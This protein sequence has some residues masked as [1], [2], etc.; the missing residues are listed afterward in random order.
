M[1]NASHYLWS[2]F[3]F[4]S[5]RFIKLEDLF[6]L[7]PPPPT[8]WVWSL[9]RDSAK[10]QEMNWFKSEYCQ[11]NRLP[12]N[13]QPVTETCMLMS[14]L[15][16]CSVALRWHRAAVCA[17]A[18]PIV[19]AGSCFN[20][21]HSVRPMSDSFSGIAYSATFWDSINTFVCLLYFRL[22]HLAVLWDFYLE[23]WNISHCNL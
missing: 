9:S 5:L 6:L 2:P 19:G 22:D 18:N 21:V 14:T 3:S 7:Q 15:N 1:W 23:H 12:Q 10:V 17:Q 11:F 8:I 16:N 13:R 4:S 20:P